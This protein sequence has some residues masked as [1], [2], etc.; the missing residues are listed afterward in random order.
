MK[1]P[2]KCDV[3]SAC[4]DGFDYI[5]IKNDGEKP[6]RAIFFLHG[7][8]RSAQESAE[9]FKKLAPN[10]PNVIFIAI[11]GPY[12]MAMTLG[13]KNYLMNE[14]LSTVTDELKRKYGVNELTDEQHLDELKNGA[15]ERYETLYAERE[16]IGRTW[17]EDFEMATVR[18]LALKFVFDR[19]TIFD[20]INH[21]VDKWLDELDLGAD[22]ASL[23]GFSLGAACAIYAGLRR[24]DQLD[25]VVSHS[26]G[27]MG[28]GKIRSRPRILMLMG[29][30]DQIREVDF[31]SS[32]ERGEVSLLQKAFCHVAEIFN[33]DH[34]HSFERMQGK[35]LDVHEVIIPG[36]DHEMTS[37]SMTAGL[38]FIIDGPEQKL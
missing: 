13:V 38:D 16:A 31:L 37:E 4:A 18:G 28:M 6:E 1:L 5:T 23:T 26:G 32:Q 7:H 33:Y 3:Q 14:A 21:F 8:G 30:N 9:I 25:S 24:K 34:R 15:M 10:Y 35:G 2:P 19:I 20:K 29:E 27:Y 12:E 22:Q 36:L 17:L 11:N